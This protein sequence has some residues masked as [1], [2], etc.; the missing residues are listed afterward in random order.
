[1]TLTVI[2]YYILLFSEVQYAENWWLRLIEN[3]THAYWSKA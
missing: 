2:V 3:E 1:M